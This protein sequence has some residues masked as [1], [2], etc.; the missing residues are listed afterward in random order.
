MYERVENIL[1]MA[2][3]SNTSAIA[4]IWMDDTM[5][6]SVVCAAEATNTPAIIMLY[7]EHVTIQ[8]TCNLSGF[9]AMVEEMAKEA[10]VPIGLHA[11][12]DY[13]YDAIINTVNKGFR[14]VMMDGSMNDLDT[15]IALT[16]KVVDKAHELGAIVEGEIGRQMRITTRRTYIPRRMPRKSSAGRH[17]RILWQSPSETP[18]ESIR[19][20]RTWTSQ[21]WKRFTQP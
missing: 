1:K 16:K 3:E 8:K 11:D 13:T 17:A 4:F 12:H 9:A 10:K 20:R 15:N 6:R 5:A 19:I 7:P 21:G 2:E 18:M 14:S